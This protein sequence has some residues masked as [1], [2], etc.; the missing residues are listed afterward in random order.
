MRLPRHIK[1]TIEEGPFYDDNGMPYAKVTVIFRWW[2]VPFAF[3]FK[4]RSRPLGS[5]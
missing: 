2:Y 4:W 5:F 3:W 1:R